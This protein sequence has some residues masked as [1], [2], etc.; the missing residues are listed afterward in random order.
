MAKIKSLATTRIE[1]TALAHTLK[2]AIFIV[3]AG[4]LAFLVENLGKLNL[5]PEQT[6]FLA[7]AIN[8]VIAW[9]KKYY[10]LEKGK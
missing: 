7:G 3:L 5:T 1:V 2:V 4:G 6:V 10:D 9:I 8:L